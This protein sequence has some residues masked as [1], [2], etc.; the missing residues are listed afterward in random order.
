MNLSDKELEKKM[1]ECSK[2]KSKFKPDEET[3]PGMYY[4]I[5]LTNFN[6]DISS[7]CNFLNLYRLKRLNTLQN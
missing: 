4:F 1:D 2:H 7:Q 6:P 5:S 3:I